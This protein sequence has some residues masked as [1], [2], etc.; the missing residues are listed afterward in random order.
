MESK[1]CAERLRACRERADETLEQIGQL[2]G[3]NRSTVLRWEKGDTHIPRASLLCLAQHYGVN[4]AWLSGDV[5]ADPP[6]A[7]M[8]ARRWLSL[9]ATPIRRMSYLPVLGSVRA[10][11]G[12]QIFEE[13]IGQ[14]AVDSLPDEFDYFWLRVTGDS[15][16]PVLNEGDLVLV[17]RQDYVNS[18]GLAVVMLGGEEGMVKQVVTGA[19]YLELHSFNPYYPVRRFER[20]KTGEVAVLGVVLESRRRFV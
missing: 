20:E 3:V 19:D 2:L 10:G 15:M 6:E 17:R 1:L 14:E 13:V 11:F 18:G 16:A 12:G 9:H 8:E 7:E 4:P 5:H